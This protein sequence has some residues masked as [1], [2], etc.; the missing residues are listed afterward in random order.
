MINKSL[1]HF[2]NDQT[3]CGFNTASNFLEYFEG[4]VF[5]SLGAGFQMTVDLSM[6]DSSN[7]NEFLENFDPESYEKSAKEFEMTFRGQPMVLNQD[8]SDVYNFSI[9]NRVGIEETCYVVPTQKKIG[10]YI[11]LF[12]S[13]SGKILENVVQ[14]RVVPSISMTNSLEF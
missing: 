13:D 7:L 10:G 4:N 11:S 3:G 9:G 5:K 12:F 6:V 14:D 2:V 8:K 1:I